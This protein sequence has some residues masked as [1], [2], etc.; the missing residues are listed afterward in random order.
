M[1]LIQKDEIEGMIELAK[2]DAG[3]LDLLEKAKSYYALKGSPGGPSIW[4]YKLTAA[5]Q[6]TLRM[7]TTYGL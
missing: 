2:T 5:E 1:L 3:M 7:N 6:R 4:A